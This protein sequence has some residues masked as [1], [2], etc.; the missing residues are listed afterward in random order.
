MRVVMACGTGT[1]VKGEANLRFRSTGISFVTFAAVQLRV[2]SG[3]R[4]AGGLVTRHGE[5]CRAKA[6]RRMA[7][8]TAVE[9]GR[10]PELRLVRI[11]VT[12]CAACIL[13]AEERGL[14]RRRVT[15]GACDRRM[16]AFERERGAGVL[17]G[18]K[19]GSFEALDGMAGTAFAAVRSLREL[20]GMGVRLVTVGAVAERDLP[21]EV[22]LGV[23]FQAIHLAMFAAQGELRARVGKLI[24]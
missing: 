6:L 5:C 3:Q 22:S 24:A 14:A 18:S 4:E 7:L 2:R 10:T 12:I 1:V 16:L 8:L 20:S 21:L 19:A 9:V 11:L 13:E 23:A 17:A 15:L